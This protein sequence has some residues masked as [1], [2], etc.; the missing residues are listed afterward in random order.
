M[1]DFDASG[2]FSLVSS[3]ESE[4]KIRRFRFGVFQVDTF[5]GELYKHGTRMKLQEQPFQVLAVLLEH[6]GEVVSR[7]ELRKRLW[8]HDT[9]VDFDHSLNISINKLRDVLG[10][11]AATPRFIETL[12]RRG[13]RF[14]APVSVESHGP[15]TVPLA[16]P[17]PVVSRTDSPDSIPSA[18]GSDLPVAPEVLARKV[19]QEE[20]EAALEKR[21]RSDARNLVAVSTAIVLALILGA[22]LWREYTGWRRSTTGRVMLAVL[23][24]ENVTRNQDEEYLVAGLHDEM[25]AQL[26]QLNPTRLGVI[27]RTSVAQYANQSKPLDQIGRELHVDYILEGT[28]RSIEG[29]VRITAGLIRVSDQTQMWVETYEPQMHDILALQ[30]D[31]A[32]RVAAALSMEFLPENK[33]KLRQHTTPNADAYEAYL[34]GRVL[35]MQETRQS[36]Q[37]SIAQFQKAIALDPGYAPAYVGLADAYNVL[38]GYGFVPPQEAFSKG[39]LAAAKAL[40]LAPN[41]SDAYSSMAFAAFYYDWNWTESERLF[42][43]ALA[44]NP[45]NQEAHEF[46]SSFLHAMGRLDDAEAENAIAQKLDPLS[47]WTHDDLGWM[48][49]SRRRPDAA[50]AEFQTAI[51]LTK[52]PAAHLSLA[53]A[54][55]RIGRYQDALEE[56]R[57]AEELGGEATRVLE[58]RG[59]A[60]ALSGDTGGAQVIVDQLRSGAVAGPI[61]PYSVALIYTAMG[62]N[63]EAL[64]WLEKAHAQ[65]DSWIVWIKVLVEWDRLRSEPRF[66]SLLRSMNL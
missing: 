58:I 22:W 16:A 66:T 30:E 34:K 56:T 17:L 8:D 53:V 28:V 50:V 61:S 25:I 29:R 37:D 54:Y 18:A 24:F 39:K 44:L 11:S 63:S 20:A 62:N 36:L 13:Y 14:I 7:E 38:G 48:L 31:V 4:S 57:K 19:N 42:R 52:F 35:W 49:L 33:E 2:V 21:P 46:Y 64:D 10:D 41:L 15:P 23:P 59:S 43:Q 1:L 45:N 26:G 12:P 55:T 27:A 60:L 3:V 5:S 6:S 9:Y 65:R 47:G 51:G 32:R 40:E